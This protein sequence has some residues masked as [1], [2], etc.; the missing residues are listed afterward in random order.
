MASELVF[1]T[2]GTGYIGSHVALVTLKAGYQVR[3]SIRRESQAAKMKEVLQEFSDKL[4]F[5]VIPDITA[6]DA[7]NDALK[8]VS[9][10]FHLASPM[11]YK[12]SDLKDYVDPAVNGTIGLLQA[13]VNFPR[14]QRIV[15][16]SSF[17]SLMPL[18]GLQDGK[19]LVKGDYCFPD[20]GDEDD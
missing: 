19:L 2:G 16:T 6:A 13:S 4:Q 17:A 12:G 18:G 3:L 9:F 14:I 8:G 5:V 10:V 1:I 7:F 20:T 15:I 11:P